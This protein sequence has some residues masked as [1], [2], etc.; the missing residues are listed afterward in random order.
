MQ[1]IISIHDVMPG[2][3]EKV[4]EIMA[5][6]P[7]SCQEN[8]ILLIVPGLDWQ[9][10]QINR[11]RQWQSQGRILAGHG[12][13]HEASQIRGVY[14]RLH[15]LLLS[16]NA[17]EHLSLGRAEIQAL[18][19]RNFQWFIDHDL[20]PPDYYVP[21]AWAMGPL[22]ATHLQS[23][24][25]RYFETTSGIYD[26]DL[27]QCHRLPL[28]GFEADTTFRKYSL[29]LWNACNT[30]LSSRQRPL[31]LSIHPDDLSLRLADSLLHYLQAVDNTVSYRTLSRH[32]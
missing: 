9:A 8:L 6:L 20:Q 19:R 5:L 15:A 29:G 21:P 23:L 14:H 27:K 17:A 2:Q 32:K 30:M 24:P 4:A 25:F 28:A 18:I 16:R 11:L 3:L 26:S 1:A 13:R 10:A 31:R 7:P 22:Q 12:W